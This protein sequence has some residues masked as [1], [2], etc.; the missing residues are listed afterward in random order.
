MKTGVKRVSKWDVVFDGTE[1]VGKV[2][3]SDG[4]SYAEAHF[5]D[6]DDAKYFF[7]MLCELKDERLEAE[8]RLGRVMTGLRVA[9]REGE[10][11]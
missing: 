1:K 7:K 2:S 8:N 9:L 10:K 11:P 3:L 4:T 6:D 5:V